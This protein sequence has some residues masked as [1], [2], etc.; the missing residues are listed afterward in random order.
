M[1]AEQEA[2]VKDIMNFFYPT[3][4]AP[5]S[6]SDDLANLAAVMLNEA[7]EKSKLIDFVP[8]PSGG[9]PGVLWLLSQ[10]VMIFWRKMGKQKIYEIARVSVAR[11]HRSE[12]ELTKAG[13]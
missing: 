8:R 2:Y 1:T 5:S 13:L 7:V 4:S 3:L 12:Y 9:R 6:V 11:D 10:A